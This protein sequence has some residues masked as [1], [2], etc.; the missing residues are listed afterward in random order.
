MTLLAFILLWVA[1]TLALLLIATLEW[2]HDD[3]PDEP[4]TLDVQNHRGDR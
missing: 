1:V 4:Q 3:V 2:G